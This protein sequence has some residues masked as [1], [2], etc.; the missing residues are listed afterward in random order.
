MDFYLMT[1]FRK[2]T[3]PGTEGRLR[4]ALPVDESSAEFDSDLKEWQPEILARYSH[5]IDDWDI[6]FYYFYG[7]SREPV[8]TPNVDGT[9][10][11]QR[12]D[13]IQ[14]VALDLQLT[15]DATLYKFEG[16]L[17]KGQGHVFGAYVAGLEHT[18]FRVFDSNADLGLLAEYLYDDRDEISYPTI[19]DNDLFVG[20]R[21]GLNDVQDTS[22]LFGLLV[23]LN[24]DSKTLRLEAERRIGDW[25]KVELESQWFANIDH[26]DPL[27]NFEK[28]NF[29]TITIKRSF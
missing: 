3:F 17:R 18:L 19:Y 11:R 24:N 28:D 22:A 6:G 15:R 2:R 7:T 9:A 1:G 27:W 14:Q 20:T 23:D 10:L 25:W 13:L 16:I 21:L 8:L 26:N 12:Y 5:F 4:T 29:L